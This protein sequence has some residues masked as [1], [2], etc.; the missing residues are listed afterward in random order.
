MR[1][2]IREPK[3]AIN[4]LKATAFLNG[5]RILTCVMADEEAG[6]LDMYQ[7]STEGCIIRGDDGKPKIQRL[8]GNVQIVVGK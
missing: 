6:V 1:L 3:D 4:A 7:T 5:E 8:F 2:D